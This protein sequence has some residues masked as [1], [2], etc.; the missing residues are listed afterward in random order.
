MD[1]FI[2]FCK[3]IEFKIEGPEMELLP[4]IASLGGNKK[5]GN[6]QVFSVVGEEEVWEWKLAYE[7]V[8]YDSFLE[9][10]RNQ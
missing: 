10:Q 3:T 2:P 5:I 8:Y 7:D 1:H 4:C 6:K 9:C